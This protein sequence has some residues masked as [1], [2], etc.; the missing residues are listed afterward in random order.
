MFF[1]AHHENLNDDIP[2]L[3]VAKMS[4]S[5]SNF[6]QYNRHKS[7]ITCFGGNCPNQKIVSSTGD[8]AALCWSDRINISVAG[9]KLETARLTPRVLFPK[10]MVRL[11]IFRM[12]WARVRAET[13][14]WQYT[15]LSHAVC[16]QCYTVYRCETWTINQS[17]IRTLDIAGTML[18]GRLK[19]V[20]IYNFIHHKW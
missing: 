20:Y 18:F 12:L 3:S 10:F 15:S 13:R 6:W 8:Q 11:I 2:I 9:S 7:Q 19:Y 17:D 1:G 16:L 4:L 14:W 5:D